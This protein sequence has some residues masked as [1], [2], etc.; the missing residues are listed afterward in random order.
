[1]VAASFSFLSLIRRCTINFLYLGRIVV[2][3]VG[4][5]RIEGKLL[6]LYVLNFWFKFFL[7]IFLHV[8]HVFFCYSH[9]RFTLV[10]GRHCTTDTVFTDTVSPPVCTRLHCSG[11]RKQVSAGIVHASRTRIYHTVQPL[12]VD[13]LTKRAHVRARQAW[14]RAAPSAFAPAS[15]RLAAFSSSRFKR[16]CPGCRG[17]HARSVGY[18]GAR[19]PPG[20][21]VASNFF[22]LSLS[23]SLFPCDGE[24]KRWREERG[25]WL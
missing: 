18:K 2:G 25:C 4:F 16:S 17:E 13:T 19:T 7:K 24:D 5:P 1:M 15:F 23:L 14:P 22:S 6:L 10:I 3:S 12:C 21:P 9:T 11:K 8:L 20:H